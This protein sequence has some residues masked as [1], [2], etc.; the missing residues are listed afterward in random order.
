MA[1]KSMIQ[2]ELK[3]N[4][5]VARQAEKRA[6]LDVDKVDTSKIEDLWQYVFDG[7]LSVQQYEAGEANALREELAEF[8]AAI[9]E[10]RP[11]LVG[12]REGLRA[13]EVAHRV[14]E[15]IRAHPW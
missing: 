8:V 11:P 2:R 12:G 13:V 1:K 3:R 10:K 7:L 4:K 15:S 5:L 6:K 14:L 9:R